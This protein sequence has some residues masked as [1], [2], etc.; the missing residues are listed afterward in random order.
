[1]AGDY[2]SL[3]K[4][5]DNFSIYHNPQV[6]QNQLLK[7]HTWHVLCSLQSPQKPSLSPSTLERRGKKKG[8]SL[9]LVLF[10]YCFVVQD[11]QEMSPLLSL[12]TL[13][14]V[15]MHCELG[16]SLS[17]HFTYRHA[18]CVT[19]VSWHRTQILPFTLWP[20]L[21]IMY[22][23]SRCPPFYLKRSEKTWKNGFYCDDLSRYVSA[24]MVLTV[25]D[26]SRS[27]NLS[28][29]FWQRRD[30]ALFAVLI[31]T[32]RLLLRSV[33]GNQMLA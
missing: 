11:V 3:L 5:K 18:Y 20:P 33:E 9:P 22:Y 32:A 10:N 21:W 19:K 30:H 7:M 27:I 17:C 13:E 15:Y 31:K 25:S 16:T 23:S 29:L 4:M 2:C 28:L 24:Q 26:W 12:K 14:S 1:M 6:W 8:W